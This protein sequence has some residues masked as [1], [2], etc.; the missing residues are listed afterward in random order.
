M[1]RENR[2]LKPAMREG[3]RGELSPGNGEGEELETNTK[4]QGT[5]RLGA[6]WEKAAMVLYRDFCEIAKHRVSL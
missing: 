1:P 5:S 4:R 2:R 6:N 3:S